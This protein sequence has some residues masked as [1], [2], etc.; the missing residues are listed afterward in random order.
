M[1]IPDDVASSEEQ[2]SDLLRELRGNVGAATQRDRERLHK[3][4]VNLIKRETATHE[5]SNTV[6]VRS[7][8]ALEDAIDVTGIALLSAASHPVV[9]VSGYHVPV[10]RAAVDDAANL[11]RLEHSGVAGMPEETASARTGVSSSVWNG[12]QGVLVSVSRPDGV[13]V[14]LRL[15][16][17]RS[18]DR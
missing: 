18:S 12:A 7:V 6:I 16:L 2:P 14:A 5:P 13:A 9:E 4:V 10:T 3:D 1:V 15:A 17:E 11:G 8:Q